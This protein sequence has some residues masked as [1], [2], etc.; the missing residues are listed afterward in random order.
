MQDLD[1]AKNWFQ[2]SAKLGFEDAIVILE[3]NFDKTTK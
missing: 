3:K 2:K 1:I